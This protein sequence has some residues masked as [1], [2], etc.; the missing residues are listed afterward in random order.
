M[1]R[2]AV[3]GAALLLALLAPAVAHA[4]P[5]LA[6]SVP[7]AGG[8]VLAG[9]PAAVVLRFDENADPVGQG[10]SVIGPDGRDATT[11]PVERI[12]RTLRRPVDAHARGTYLVEWL[13]V[14][15]DTHPARGA[16]LF[17]VGGTSR[18]SIPGAGRAGVAL[19]AVGRWIS[20]VGFVLGFGVPFAAAAL[21]AGMTRRQWRLV[22]VGIAA[23]VVA[24]PISLLG[25][26]ATLSPAHPFSARLAG[27]VLLTSYGHATGLR[28]GAALAL[29]SVVGAVRG[30]TPKALWAIPALGILVAIVHADA[31]HRIEGLP[32]AVALGLVAVHVG[33]AAAWVGCVVVA[34]FGQ[35][36]TA[37]R[38][39]P[40]A[41]RV[42]AV[43]VASGVGLA[44]GHVRSFHELIDSSYGLAVLVKVAV[45]GTALSLAIARRH[46]A[47]AVAGFAALAA[48]AVLVALLPPV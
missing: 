8:G 25:Q 39:A 16:F 21:G 19:Q 24:E 1:R 15:D 7:S 46:R 6:S 28:L 5:R 10:I 33:A 38:I 41:A 47:E 3:A 34:A 2:A 37:R 45:V 43:A 23:M 44:I 48:A 9:A 20:L 4:H 26:T 36:G 27:D 11:G 22:A 29:W 18:T 42:A 31:A 12:G 32:G 17:S 14:G 30:A 40:H 35:A 13:A